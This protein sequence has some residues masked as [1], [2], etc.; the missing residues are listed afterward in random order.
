M[1][2]VNHISG[3]LAGV[4]MTKTGLNFLDW[5]SEKGISIGGVPFLNKLRLI[6]IREVSVIYSLTFKSRF[7]L[8]SLKRCG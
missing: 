6:I 4:E 1:P 8:L 3:A 2:I 5:R 7:M